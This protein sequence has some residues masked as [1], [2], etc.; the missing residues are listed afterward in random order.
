MR[1]LLVLGVGL[2]LG[3]VALQKDWVRINWS[4]IQSDLGVHRFI[5]PETNRIRL[6]P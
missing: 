4:R 6:A 3:T 1:R 5:D 2:L